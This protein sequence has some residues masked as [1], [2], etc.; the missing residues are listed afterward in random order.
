MGSHK[1]NYFVLFAPDILRFC[2]YWAHD[3][4]L[5]PKLVAKCMM[6]MIMMMI[7]IIIIIKTY[8]CQREYI[9]YF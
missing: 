3:G 2:I 4:L 6:M 5:K 8:S 1:V 7:I 9:I